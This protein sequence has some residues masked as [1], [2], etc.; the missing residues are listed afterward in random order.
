MPLPWGGLWLLVPLAV[1]TALLLSWRFGAWGLV[2][3]VTLAAAMLAL[4]RAGGSWSWWVPTAGLCGCWMGLGEE[5]VDS[6]SGAKAWMLLPVLVL[7]ALLPR[8][9]HYA[10][11]VTRVETQMRQGDTES[12]QLWRELG[13][14]ADKIASMQAFVHE[15]AESRTRALPYA[16]PTVLFL[17]VAVLVYAG[18]SLSAR[19]AS[20]MRWPPLSRGRL[21]E[22]RMPDGA[23]WAFLAGL[24]LLIGPW[25]AWLAT[26]WTL[27]LNGG[28][29]FC[30]QGI[31]VVESWLL[32]RG[33]PSSVIVLTLLFVFAVAMPVF[34]LGTA[35]VGLSDAWLDFRHLEPAPADNGGENG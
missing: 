3:P 19:A 32:A 9:A 21:R 15:N 33:V 23:L 6:G 22:W 28:I 18:R 10:S 4:G 12:L 24:A 34:V 26:G 16:L 5:H 35:V 8:T 31:A 14:S 7:A 17:W 29:A 20:A 13:M 11:M 27:L 1:A 30:V 2:V 25:P